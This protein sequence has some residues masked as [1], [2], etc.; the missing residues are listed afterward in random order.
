[1]NELYCPR[2]DQ[3]LD[4]NQFGISR[5]R[6]NGRNLYC[7]ICIRKLVYASR[8][9]LRER[10]R[11][12]KQALTGKRPP[13]QPSLKFIL[14]P[15]ERV[16]EALKHGAKTH[17]ELE[18]CADVLREDLGLI[19]A[20]LLV[21]QRMIGTRVE[22][23]RRLYFIREVQ[24]KAPIIEPKSEALP[25]L[26]HLLGRAGNRPQGWRWECPVGACSI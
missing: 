25:S 19:L 11:A 9:A 14:S 7:K 3:K 10:D 20:R 17:Y 2:C 15:D 12:R 16:M 24:S 1:M 5:A 13:A 4:E 18:R 6:P 26:L 21:D 23:G 22:Q 8:Q